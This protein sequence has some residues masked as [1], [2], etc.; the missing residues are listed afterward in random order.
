[1]TDLYYVQIARE[2]RCQREARNRVQKQMDKLAQDGR[3]SQRPPEHHL[4]QHSL[5]LIINEVEKRISYWRDASREGKP[6]KDA[7]TYSKLSK[8]T[9]E[10][11]HLFLAE[12][13]SDC[14]DFSMGRKSRCN[15]MMK[16]GA[17]LS[18]MFLLQEQQANHAKEY[19][20]AIKRMRQK[21][22]NVSVLIPFHLLVKLLGLTSPLKQRRLKVTLAYV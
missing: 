15:L 14:I 19:K 10:N 18:H 22:R 3:H 8:L 17:R 1:M 6:S 7:D 16:I 11:L 9:K 12:S 20:K 2:E 21:G 5:Y 13:L 4:I